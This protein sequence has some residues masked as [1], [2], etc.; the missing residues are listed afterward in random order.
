MQ[1]ASSAAAILSYKCGP[2][3]AA[4]TVGTIA[5]FTAFTSSVHPMAHTGS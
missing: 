3:L 2:Q 1:E 4:L 5:A